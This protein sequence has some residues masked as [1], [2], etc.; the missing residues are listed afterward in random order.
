[1]LVV[2]A[3]DAEDITPPFVAESVSWNFLCDFLVIEDTAEKR[4]AMSSASDKGMVPDAQS[5]LIIDVEEFL[6]PSGGVWKV[7]R[8]VVSC[9][10]R[11]T[12]MLTG[13]VKLHTEE[14][15]AFL[16]DCRKG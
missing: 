7:V 6:G 9:P 12:A 2:S 3:G 10:L 14:W 13:D 4:N 16:L 11:A 15:S 8:K 5:L 1:M